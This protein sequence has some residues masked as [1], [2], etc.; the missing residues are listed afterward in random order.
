MINNLKYL[1]QYENEITFS[2]TIILVILT[3]III[4]KFNKIC[5]LKKEYL[6]S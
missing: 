2:F 4:Y 5:L 3:I 6:F 1:F